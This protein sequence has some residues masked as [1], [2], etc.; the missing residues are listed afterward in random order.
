MPGASELHL[1]EAWVLRQAAAPHR[2]PTAIVAVAIAADALHAVGP[3]RGPAGGLVQ[4]RLEGGT[5]LRAGQGGAAPAAVGQ[6]RLGAGGSGGDASAPT[7]S[8]THQLL[9]L[10]FVKGCGKGWRG[11]REG[12]GRRG[13]SVGRRQPAQVGPQRPG[14]LGALPAITG[15][16]WR[17]GQALGRAAAFGLRRLR[18]GANRP[19]LPLG[20]HAPSAHL[21]PLQ[22]PGRPPAPGGPGHASFSAGGWTGTGRGRCCVFK[23]CDEVVG[24][25]R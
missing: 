12:S 5:E 11:W 20:P 18:G 7:T 24:V 15:A 25:E 22:P 21:W 9:G 23:M 6:W 13:R 17:L 14:S 4:G 10:R 8:P 19:S 1:G 16:P 2:R 3:A